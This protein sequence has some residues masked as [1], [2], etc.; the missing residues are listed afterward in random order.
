MN[1]L[2]KVNIRLFNQREV[3]VGKRTQGRTREMAS[4]GIPICQ[5]LINWSKRLKVMVRVSFLV[6]QSGEFGRFVH[7]GRCVL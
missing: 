4:K 7:L 3:G 5:G 2:W 1:Q 6:G